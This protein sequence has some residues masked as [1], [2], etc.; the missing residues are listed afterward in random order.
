MRVLFIGGTGVISTACTALAV[1][2]G[3]ELFHLN[4][5]TQHVAVPAGVITLRG[6]IRQPAAVAELLQPYHFDAVVEWVAYEPA[7]IDT[8]LAL[9]AGKTDQYVFI[10]TTATYQKPAAYYCMSESTPQIN[11]VW[12]Y[13]QQKIAC[14]ERLRAAYRQGDIPITIVRPSHTYGDTKIPYVVGSG[15]IVVDRMRRGKPTI[16]PGDG[17]SLWTMTHNTDFA[18]GLIGLLGNPQ[19]LG[20]SFHITADEVLTWEQ[21]ARIIGKAA[22]VPD[23]PLVR[24]PSDLIGH[25][26]ATLGTNLLGDKAYNGVFDNGKIKRAVPGY[27]ATT[28]F[29]DGI[30]RAIAWHDADPARR[31][32]SPELDA[33]LDRIVEAYQ[34][35]W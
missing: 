34:R 30:R 17:Q 7:H 5:G 19:A 8:D 15:Y 26:D 25:Y 32:V 20:E 16:L 4:R 2:R 1:E 27:L 18:K 9:F 11:P 14:E 13:A 3:I 23:P 12:G 35:A 22:G 21:I 10:S 31:Q 33:T 24:I 6:D 28:S 29:S